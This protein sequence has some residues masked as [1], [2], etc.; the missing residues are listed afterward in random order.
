MPDNQAWIQLLPPFLRARLDG[1]YTLQKILGNIGWLFADRILRMGVGLFVGV[2]IA[3]YLGPEQFGVLNYA[4]ALVCL[5]SA[6]A[7]LGLDGILVRNIVQEPDRKDE[8]LGTAFV[9]K[10]TGGIITWLLTLTLTILLRPGE[11]LTHWLVG[12]TAA[13]LIFQSLDTID[14]WFQSQVTSKYTVFARSAAFGLITLLKVLLIQQQA[15]LIAFA[16][17]GL[18]EVGI[19]ATGLA[20]AYGA[21][22][23]LLIAWKASYSLAKQLLSDS[24][25]LIFSGILIA[26]YTRIDQVMLAEM[27]GEQEVGLYS[28]AVRLAEAWYFIPMTIVTSTFPNIVEARQANESLFYHKLQNLYRLMALLSYGISIPTTIFSSLI[29]LTLFGS[30]YTKASSMLAV[31]I[32]SGLFVSLGT[33]R[34][35][36]LIA[37]NQTRLH[38]MTVFWGCV[39]NVSLNFILIPTHGGIGAAIATSIAYW[40]ATHGACYLHPSLSKTGGMLTKAIVFLQRE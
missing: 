2:W 15:P 36:F 5:F 16:W 24:L 38:M 7:T 31:L 25:P 29:I 14:F 30:E 4:I 32:W 27:V 23:Q 26:I 3:R 12:I 39:I 34:S 18:A 40:F 10:F 20:I 37:M 19:S 8:I 17:A 22:G 6:L 28:A 13:G 21:T 35:S 33:A 1:R 11:Y 9:L